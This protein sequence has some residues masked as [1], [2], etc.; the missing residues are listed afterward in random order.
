LFRTSHNLCAASRPCRAK[1]R[2]GSQTRDASGPCCQGGLIEPRVLLGHEDQDLEGVV[3]LDGIELGHSD[4]S[5]T[6]GIRAP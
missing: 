5:A 2:A 1:V 3:Q 6:L 4:L